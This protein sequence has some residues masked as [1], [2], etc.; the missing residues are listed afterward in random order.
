VSIDLHRVYAATAAFFDDDL[1]FDRGRLRDHFDWLLDNGV[2]GLTPNGSLGEYQ[3]LSGD[4][5]AA[6]VD[7]AVESVAGRDGLVLPGVAG[8]TTDQ[9]VRWATQAREAGAHGVMALPPTGYRASEDE[10]L[11]HYERL[12]EVGLPIVLYNNPF[13][14]RVDLVPGLVAKIAQFDNVVGIKEFSCDVRRVP[15]I[16]D[17][18]PSIAVL[19]GADDVLLESLLVGAA[20]WIS[21]FANS[22]PRTCVHLLAE[23]KAGRYAEAAE[24]YRKVLPAFRWD[25]KPKFVQAIKRA[26]DDIGQYGGPTRSPRG[27]LTGEEIAVLDPQLAAAAEVERSLA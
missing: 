23:A 3:A 21:G 13:D 27:P 24:I 20:G 22:Y 4:E 2:G 14:T 19:G 9:S 1:V 25:S 11:R 26:L 15:E 12:S 17:E 8:L 16:L 5:R 10:V 7:V 18:V 6:A